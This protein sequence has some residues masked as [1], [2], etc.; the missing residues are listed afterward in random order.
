MIHFVATNRVHACNVRLQESV[1]VQDSVLD[2][3]VKLLHFDFQDYIIH[4][5]LLGD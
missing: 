3:F 4:I 5:V 2:E 1:L